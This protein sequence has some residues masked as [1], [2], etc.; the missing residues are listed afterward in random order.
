[1]R[2]ILAELKDD[3]KKTNES[4]QNWN[5]MKL[6]FI[7]T[8][9]D[10]LVLLNRILNHSVFGKNF[11]R[12]AWIAI[13]ILAWSSVILPF[14]KWQEFN[15]GFWIRTFFALFITIGWPIFYARYTHGVFSGII[16]E[17]TMIGYAGKVSVT[18]SEDFIRA[19]TQTTCSQCNWSNIHLIEKTSQ[20]ILIFFTPL[21]AMPVPLAAFDSVDN[22]KQFIQ[23]IQ[24]HIQV[25]FV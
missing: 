17:R 25:N 20:H 3:D 22:L 11:S 9:N 2:D 6:E 23:K 8:P 1:M 19:E 14:I 18:I 4:L 12:F 5:I 13:S 24:E 10:Y 16:N 15:L 7:T 21:V